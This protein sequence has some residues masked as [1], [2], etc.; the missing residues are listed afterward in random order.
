[1]NSHM[2]IHWKIIYSW[3]RKS[4][5]KMRCPLLILLFL[6]LNSVRA[7][8]CSS[9]D[10]KVIDKVYSETYCFHFQQ[11]DSIISANGVIYKDNLQFNLAVINYYWWRYISGKQNGKFAEMVSIRI[12]TIE[13][14][15]STRNA[16]IGNGEL[17][18]LISIFSYNARIDLM[19]NSYFAAISNLSKYYSFLKLSIGSEPKY[20]PFY[21]TSGLFFYFSGLTK[22]RV[23]FLSPIL[24]Q[25]S[26]G[27]MATGLIYLKKAASSE[28]SKISQEAKY[29]LM[30]INFDIQRNYV[31]AAKYCNQ[32]LALYPDNLLFQLY[33]FRISLALEQVGLAKARIAIMKNTAINNNQLSA[34]EKDFYSAQAKS[35]LDL[36]FDKK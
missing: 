33:M 4:N 36:Y 13:E 19:G 12:K 15:Y 31:E 2:N 29:F 9:N 27:D 10:Q 17:F 14:M 25:Y 28:D 30:K 1:M 16:K 35:E 26:A 6:L 23:P 8:S 5:C 24:N 3:C 22:E 21:L 34:D 32:L 20:N 11:V 18:F 7:S